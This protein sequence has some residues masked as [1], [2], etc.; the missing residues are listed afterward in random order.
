[1]PIARTVFAL[2]LLFHLSQ[3]EA[4]DLV[5]NEVLYDPP[6]SDA[7]AEYVEL[8][9]PGDVALSLD[10]LELWFLNAGIDGRRVWVALPGLEVPSRGFFLIGEA[11]V[12]GAD[13]VTSLDLQNGPDALHLV[14]EGVVVDAV[15]W[16]DEAAVGGEGRAAPDATSSSIGR[17]PDGQDTDDNARDFRALDRA[18]P[19]EVNLAA[20]WF[21]PIPATVDP[22]WRADPGELRWSPRWIARGWSPSQSA[23]V[24]IEGKPWTLE[25]D[26]GDTVAID[27]HFTLDVGNHVFVHSGAPEPARTE[28]TRV[29][30]GPVAVRLTEIQ[31]RPAPGEPEW[32]E[33]FNAGPDAVHL[34]GW[35]LGDATSA[36]EMG[37]VGSLP[38][39]ARWIVT[40]DPVAWA[41]VYGTGAFVVRPEGGWSTLNDG[42]AGDPLPADAVRLFDAEGRLVDRASYRRDDLGER[43]QSLQR[44]D[45]V[46]AGEVLW[47]LTAG[48]PTPGLEH[49]S[50]G[51]VP[52]PD[53]LDVGPDPFSPDGDAV[54][55]LLQ[56]V[57][58]EPGA[59]PRATV[60]DL[61]GDEVKRLEGAVGPA[62]AH[63]Q[64]DGTDLR[65]RPAPV[66]AYVVQVRRVDDGRVWRRVVGL[67]RR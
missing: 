1:M 30:V 13:V 58:E 38:P 51:F 24:E 2:V 33:L 59:D 15:A 3:A 40:A 28:S 37:V 42:R 56:V 20:N 25:A 35:A 26:A 14:R 7:N 6:G 45:V 47:I 10:G 5:V 22:P 55:D 67:G 44:T 8:F 49:P 23:G 66:G 12:D 63:W 57:L 11:D 27:L 36:R 32:V 52:G 54:D 31:P 19:G 50:E 34:A 39:G 60:Y 29:R 41:A 16:G 53:P 4:R 64:W 17:V 61:F 43:G 18:T 46:V 21:D 62:R 65:G 48:D 9:N